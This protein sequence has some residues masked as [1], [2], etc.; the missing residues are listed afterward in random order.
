MIL[1]VLGVIALIA[2]CY[3]GF[4]TFSMASQNEVWNF[5]Y[6][7]L[8]VGTGIISVLGFG[9]GEALAILEEISMK[10]PSISK[11]QR[12]RVREMENEDEYGE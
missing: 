8:F 10:M 12:K 11:R 5:G 7:M 3:F 6:T 2:C 4:C 9:F 1:S